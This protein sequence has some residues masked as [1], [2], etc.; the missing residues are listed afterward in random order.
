MLASLSSK[1]KIGL[2][3][4]TLKQLEWPQQISMSY[5][6]VVHQALAIYKSALRNQVQCS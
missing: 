3:E 5:Q 4:S 1:L 6:E 2:T